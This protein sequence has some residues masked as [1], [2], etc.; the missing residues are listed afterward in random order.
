MA[1]KPRSLDTFQTRSTLNLNGKD[2]E[3]F[4]LSK[5]NADDKLKQ[6]PIA[7]KI[8]LENMLRFEDNASVTKD[9][10]QAIL[11]W[12]AKATPAHEIQL[13][14]IT[15]QNNLCILHLFNSY[16]LF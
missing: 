3:Y 5:L 6:L 1:I 8:L 7:H 12:D 16:R 2:H 14:P 13:I 10:V 15:P 4:A 9:D 11:N